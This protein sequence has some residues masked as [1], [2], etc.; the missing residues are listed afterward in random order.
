MLLGIEFKRTILEVNEDRFIGKLT[1]CPML[2]ATETSG[3]AHTRAL[4]GERL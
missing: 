1:A 3:I 4:P 2:N